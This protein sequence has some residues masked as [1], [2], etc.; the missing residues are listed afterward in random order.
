MMKHRTRLAAAA[1]AVAAAGIIATTGVMA[2]AAAPH[3]A[4]AATSGTETFQI[5]TTSATAP[6]SSAIAFGLFTEPG[7]ANGSRSSTK[8]TFPNGAVM[9]KHSRG[10]GQQSVNP[11]TC[12]VTIN[13]HGTFTVTAG[14]GAYSGIGGSGTYK[15]TVLGIAGRSGGKCS[16]S[17][18]P[19]AWHQVITATGSVSLP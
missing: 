13:A 11:Q 6:T 8:I 1:G 18:P 3:P 7:T 15:L 19:V 2:A 14:T 16:M 17:K 4:R 10:K 5:M 12:L 9:V